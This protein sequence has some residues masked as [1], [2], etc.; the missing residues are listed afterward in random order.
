VDPQG[1]KVLRERVGVVGK[2][3]R[4]LMKKKP[5]QEKRSFDEKRRPA[6]KR[7]EVKKKR[8][9]RKRGRATTPSLREAKKEL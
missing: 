1:K 6:E 4:N 9:R 3:E 2:V 7:S 8:R 5:L